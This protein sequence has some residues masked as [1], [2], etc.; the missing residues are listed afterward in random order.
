MKKKHKDKKFDKKLTTVTTKLRKKH[1][2]N[3]LQKNQPKKKRMSQ[4]TKRNL[5]K[6]ND[7]EK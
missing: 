4:E 2:L 6:K 1:F 5:E 3:L 7:N